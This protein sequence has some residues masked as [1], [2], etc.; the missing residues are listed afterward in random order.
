MY[1]V[2]N[3][4]SSAYAALSVPGKTPTV[5]TYLEPPNVSSTDYSDCLSS[6]FRGTRRFIFLKVTNFIKCAFM[7]RNKSNGRR[8]LLTAF[9]SYCD[10][11]VFNVVFTHAFNV[12]VSNQYRNPNSAPP[13]RLVAQQ[14]I[15]NPTMCFGVQQFCRKFWLDLIILLGAL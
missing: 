14:V 2:T 8:R 4:V 3:I 7:D 15:N 1:V 5:K 9:I 11:W 13:T 10:D 6:S 12:V